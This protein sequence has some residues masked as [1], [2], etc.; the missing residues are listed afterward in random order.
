MQ[1]SHVA[2]GLGRTGRTGSSAVKVVRV[3]EVQEEG[4]GADWGPVVG[5]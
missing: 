5:G 4:S 1:S 3:G 2:T